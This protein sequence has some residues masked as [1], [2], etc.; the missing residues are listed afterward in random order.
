VLLS[1]GFAAAVWAEDKTS[2][3]VKDE[4]KALV[5]EDAKSQAAKPAVA[6]TANKPV[7]PGSI[8]APPVLAPPETAAPPAQSDAATSPAAGATPAAEK[9]TPP[10]TTMPTVEVN[11][12]K[13]TVL[14]HELYEQDKKI[15]R[16]AKATKATETDNALNAPAINVPILGGASS[17]VRTDLA[18]ERVELMEEEK[19]LIEA[20]AHAKTKE[21]RAEL[22]KQLEDIR[23]MRRTLDSPR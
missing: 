13:I 7:K 15:A 6:P 17:K 22:K 18:K 14:D 23:T 11:K 2:S 21:D 12:P 19:D 16:E 4:I 10:P 8:P 1:T 20:I 3:T 9:A 5:K